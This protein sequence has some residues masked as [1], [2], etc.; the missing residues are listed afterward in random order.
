M[1]A[2]PEIAQINENY[3]ALR[4]DL[5][6]VGHSFE[7]AIFGLK[8][9]L[10]DQ[11]WKQ[12]GAGFDDPQKFL[13]SIRLDQFRIVAEER[14][15]IAKLIKEAV[16]GASN[17][18]IAKAL[19]V[20]NTTINKDIGGGFPPPSKKK[21]NGNNG[22][23]TPGGGNPP[24]SGAQAARLALRS[25]RAE[26]SRNERLDRIA[27]ISQGNRALGTATRYPII[28]ADPPWRYENPPLSGGGANHYP[29][30]TLAEICE[31][32]VAD[33]ATD[34]ALLYLWATA[35]N[36]PGCFQALSAWRFEYRTCFVW[37]KDKAGMGYHARN[38]HELLIV[39][40]R[41]DIP[42]PAG[43]DRVSSVVYADRGKHSEKPDI[44][45]DLIEG[46]YPTL[47]RIEL[48]AREERPGWSA[49]GN[50]VCDGGAK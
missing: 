20:D 12:A 46:W 13:E 44:F 23:K 9:L 4:T 28:Y 18:Q 29:T 17:R 34:D 6:Y 27:E 39:A 8:W 47:P 25:E 24:L 22:S 50:Q 15:A 30:L 3:G 45:Y 1:N 37:V 33:L 26:A 49:W 11:R 38:Q 43:S 48:F 40:K 14:Q 35:P 2:P 42:P 16:A 19:G 7:R 32:P 21:A 31:L 10:Q 5:Y 41:G 36:L